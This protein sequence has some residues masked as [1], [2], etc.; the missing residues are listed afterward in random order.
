MKAP[1]AF[2]FIQHSYVWHYNN[3]VT[4]RADLMRETWRRVRENYPGA[5]EPD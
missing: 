3:T 5:V 2:D 4:I 1:G